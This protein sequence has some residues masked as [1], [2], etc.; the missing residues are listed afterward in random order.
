MHA[1]RRDTVHLRPEA[2]QLL[3]LLG[4]DADIFQKPGPGKRKSTTVAG[5]TP[6]M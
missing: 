5:E 2:Y 4:L 3:K 6:G 1:C